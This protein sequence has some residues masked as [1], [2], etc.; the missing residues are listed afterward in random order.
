MML[1]TI[2]EKKKIIKES[3]SFKYYFIILFAF[4]LLFAFG[5]RVLSEVK[6]HITLGLLTTAEISSIQVGESLLEEKEKLDLV[7]EAL[8]DIKW[9]YPNGRGWAKPIP[10]IINFK[11]G[12]VV[13]FRIGYH[14]REEEGAVIH[15]SGSGS[16]FSPRL[17]TALLNIGVQL[18][19][20]K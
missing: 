9:F 6:N 19:R 12:Q 17:P 3:S 4:F 13:R 7:S 2:K 20:K 11:D 5:S 18:P 10:L 15:F 1:M 16:A 14:L 8:R